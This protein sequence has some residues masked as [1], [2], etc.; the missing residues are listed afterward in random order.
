MK[1][2]NFIKSSSLAS[3]PFL[4]N[5]ISVQ[6]FLSR[7]L[8]NL[9]NGDN[10][11]VLV[12]IQLNGGNDGLNTLI[13][14]D[15]YAGLTAVRTPV[16][17]PQNRVIKINNNTGLH[18]SMTELNTVWNNGM[19]QFI[20]AVGYPNQNRSHF[21]SQDIWITASD[22]NEFLNTAWLGRYFDETIPN[23]PIG[24]PNSDCPDPIALSIGTNI[25]ETCQGTRG[26]YSL[27]VIDPVNID[28]L[29]DPNLEPVPSTCYGEELSFLRD[30]VKQTN[31][32]TDRIKAAGQKGNNLSTKYSTSALSEKLKTVAKLISGGLKTKV[33][34]VNLMGFDNHSGQVNS[35]TTTGTHANLL[36]QLSNAICAF[37]DDLV[38]LK[39]D[40]RVIGMTFSEFGRRIKT[41]NNGTDHGSAAP[42]I[43]F[44]SCI[45]PVILGNN[46][47]ISTTTGDQEGVAMQYDFRSVYGS[48]LNQWFNVDKAIVQRLIYQQYQ[49]LPII[50]GCTTTDT[51]DINEPDS[52]KIKLSENITTNQTTLQI[53]GIINKF[54]NIGV[55]N[56]Q[57]FQLQNEIIKTS[58][59]D[60][61]TRIINLEQYPAGIYFVR[62]A[63]AK[64]QKVER[65]VKVN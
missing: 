23:Y 3:T 8:E 63:D 31:S 27:A 57:G 29:N 34:V 51:Y 1:R 13:P 12:L 33:Y 7:S 28:V 44:G 36:T 41:T 25:S 15:Q 14:I 5:G 40:K 18:P 30:A 54:V 48:I 11:R 45:N 65:V 39:L 58:G 64:Y 49:D 32:Y 38:K 55:F 50:M 53:N 42:M 59:V 56:D 26:N 19:A 46:P 9:I 20:Q 4:L 47:I 43:L 6:S 52:L 21:R 10:D 24:Y 35:D 62:V 16:L 61:I 22:A 17:I 37:Q 60:S 2:R